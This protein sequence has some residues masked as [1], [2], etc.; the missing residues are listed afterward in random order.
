MS[1]N[2]YK[3]FLN[4]PKSFAELRRAILQVPDMTFAYRFKTAVHYVSSS[5]LAHNRGFLKKSPAKALTVLAV[6][7]GVAL[8]WFI[9][10][11]TKQ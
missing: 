5:I 7:F 11:K 10:Y 4:S 6:P 1:A 8:T 3:Q 2:V 9:R